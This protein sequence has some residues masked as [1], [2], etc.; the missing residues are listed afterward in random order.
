MCS[1]K[2]GNSTIVEAFEDAEAGLMPARKHREVLNAGPLENFKEKQFHIV[3]QGNRSIGIYK[4]SGKVYA[5]RNQ[6]PHMGAPLCLGNTGSTYRPAEKGTSLFTEVLT[7][8]VI[9]CPWHGWEFDIITGR[10]LYDVKSR[11]STFEVR[12][13]TADEIEILI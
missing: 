4:L 8:R 9:R 10:G 1:S 7:D 13:N 11:V 2:T 6:C 12:I 5:I 3:K